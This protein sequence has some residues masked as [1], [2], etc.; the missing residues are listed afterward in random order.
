MVIICYLYSVLFSYL[1]QLNGVERIS[2]CT[3]KA[4]STC[5][6]CYQKL[7]W[8]SLLP[9]VSFLFLKGRALCCH[10]KLNK[11]YLIGE[12]IAFII[13]TMSLIWDI[14]INP[15]IFSFVFLFLLVMAIYDI[16][17]KYL[18]LQFFALFVICLL[19]ISHFYLINFIIYTL[20]SHAIYLFVHN[21]LG[22]GD[23]ILI[24]FLSLIFPQSFMLYFIFIT[25]LLA[26]LYSL[27]L[28]VKYN[29][30]RMQIPLIPFVFISF[31]LN[32]F[33]F[34]MLKFYVEG[35]ML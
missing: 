12:L 9:I 33:C 14:D 34:K 26:T 7:P 13:P 17:T 6:Y 15:T 25:I 30:K 21:S 5:D 24:S 1:Y 19:F 22:Y 8:Y 3:L 16:E 35:M 20:V 11:Y 18:N 2:F 10:H 32:A 27:F 31:I 23:I 4:R 28:I 29:T